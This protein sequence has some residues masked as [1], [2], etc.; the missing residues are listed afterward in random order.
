M[1]IC[2][3]GKFGRCLA[4]QLLKNPNISLRGYARDPTKVASFISSS[5]RVQLFQGEAYDDAQIQ[6]FVKGCDVIVCAYLGDDKLMI[7]GQKKLIDVCEMRG[8]PRYIA[9]DWCVDYTKLQ[10]GD[11][12]PKDPMKHVKAYLDT[13]QVVKGVH[14]LIGAFMDPILSPYYGVWD[15][16]S[17]T[18]RY[19]GEG[20]ELLEATSYENSAEFT[21]AV[22]ADPS[23]VGIQ[24]FLGDSK[25]IKEIAE[26]LEKVHG[27][28]PKLERLGSLED[29]KTRMHA[30]RAE[31]PSNVFSYMSLYY[32]Y[33]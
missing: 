15:P 6:P 28:K 11:L 10:L 20:N 27:I 14:M 9:S 30:L 21:A 22:A 2:I 23:A 33:Y 18:L 25:T 16:E 3:T 31:K 32:L 7:E 17:K 19:W 1:Y 24:R 8:V 12:F 13:K 29:L 4:T 26:S 5:P